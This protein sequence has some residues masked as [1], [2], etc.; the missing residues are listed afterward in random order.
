MAIQS[1]T[2]RF[3]VYNNL[4]SK[5]KLAACNKD[6]LA[7]ADEFLDYLRSGG[8]SKGTVK[9]YQAN[10]N[11]LWCWL[12][13]NCDN[14]F[15]VDIKKREAIRF[16]NEAINKWGWS[17]KRVRTVRATFCSLENYVTDILD[18]DYPLYRPV[19]KKIKAPV[20]EPI[21]DKTVYK[22]EEL[23]E[24]LDYF[25]QHKRYMEACVLALAMSSGRR[26]AELCRF[27]THYFD[28]D[29]LICSG[30]MYRTPEKVQCKGRK[31]QLYVL[32]KPFDHYF[33][34]WMKER[35]RLGITSEWLFPKPMGAKSSRYYEQDEHINPHTLDS[36][37]NIISELTDKPFYWHSMRHYFTTKL[38]QQHLPE[39]VIQD[40]IGWKS[41]DMVRLYDDTGKEEKFEQ[42]FG[43]DGIKQVAQ[44]SLNDL[45]EDW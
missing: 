19:F 2:A 6:N 42:Y 7:L 25:V 45:D 16:Q 24:V 20:D 4:T 31:M 22:T 43:E 11:I 17:P 44:G 23:K 26:K 35:E 38:K 29:N 10:L 9:A 34:L 30:A 32:R 1:K 14:K 37:T 13:D 28:E 39:D 3:T 8:K 36:W 15:F 40:I 21:R 18:E 27:K 33:N 12:F 41:A 5:E